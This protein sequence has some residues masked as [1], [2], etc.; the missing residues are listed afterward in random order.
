MENHIRDQ[1][2]YAYLFAEVALIELSLKKSHLASPHYR[3][4]EHEN[5]LSVALLKTIF[6]NRYNHVKQL[7]TAYDEFYQPGTDF[8]FSKKLELLEI[9]HKGHEALDTPKL[10][11]SEYIEVLKSWAKWYEES[12]N[13]PENVVPTSSLL[14]ILA[15][16][17]VAEGSAPLDLIPLSMAVF[18][19]RML[20]TMCEYPVFVLPIHPDRFIQMQ[21]LGKLMVDSSKSIIVASSKDALAVPE[22]RDRIP[23]SGYYLGYDNWIKARTY[24]A[25]GRLTHNA[26]THEA[27]GLYLEAINIYE[28]E[29]MPSWARQS[30]RLRL[31]QLHELLAEASEDTRL[32]HHT[33][34]SLHW[35]EIKRL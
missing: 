4:E 30:S 19:L 3:L 7:K 27:Y 6:D 2:E 11:I 13:T 17:P 28:K 8:L 22:K 26:I 15:G 21:Q 20:G 24:E 10:E 35:L 33:Q 14:S 9:A 18:I 31:V 1:L 16:K 5:R 32:F 29:K 25:L 23:L 34:A 12:R